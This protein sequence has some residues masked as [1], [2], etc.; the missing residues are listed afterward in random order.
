MYIFNKDSPS[1]VWGLNRSSQRRKGYLLTW[2]LDQHSDSNS[3][4]CDFEKILDNSFQKLFGSFSFFSLKTAHK[5]STFHE[6]DYIWLVWGLHLWEPNFATWC[7]EPTHWERPWF[8][9][10]LRTRGEEGTR[11]WDG[12]MASLTQWTWVWANSGRQWRTG[13]LSVL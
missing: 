3:F 4:S 2:G 12:W 8:W 13:K 9:G 5:I 1:C 10:R 7:E 6:P 11:G